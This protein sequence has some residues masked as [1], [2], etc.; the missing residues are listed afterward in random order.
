MKKARKGL[1]TVKFSSFEFCIFNHAGK[2]KQNNCMWWGRVVMDLLLVIFLIEF[3]CNSSLVNIEAY[4][5]LGHI[6]QRF[7]T[8]YIT[9]CNTC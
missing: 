8:F 7:H 6:I 3:Y 5:I 4:I 2:T 9:Q 1:Q